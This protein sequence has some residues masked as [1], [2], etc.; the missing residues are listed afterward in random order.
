MTGAGG[1]TPRFS[2][3]SSPN[4]DVLAAGAACQITYG[5]APSVIGPAI[6]TWTGI[7]GGQALPIP[8]R[9]NG[10]AVA[11]AARAVPALPATVAF[12]AGLLLAAIGLIAIRARRNSVAD[13]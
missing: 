2:F 4:C 12:A 9:G 13:C 8:L 1:L 3:S 7:W 6:A 10:I 11:P 5:F